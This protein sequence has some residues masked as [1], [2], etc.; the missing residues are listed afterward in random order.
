[1]NLITRIF[2]KTTSVLILLS[3]VQMHSLIFAQQTT[4]PYHESFESGLGNWTQ[5]TDEDFDWIENTGGTPSAFTGPNEAADGAT[6]LYL[7]SSGDGTGYPHKV[8]KLTSGVFDLSKLSTP[9][10]SFA[11]HMYG[12]NIGKLDLQIS[13]DNGSNWTSIWLKNGDQTNNWLTETIDL[14]SYQSNQVMFRFIGTTGDSFRSD[15]AIDRIQIN[16]IGALTVT[17]ISPTIAYGGSTITLTGSGFSTTPGDHVVKINGVQVSVISAT[18]TE[19]RIVLPAS[20]SSDRISVEV[21]GL[22]TSSGV[23]LIIPLMVYPYT[24]SFENGMGMWIQESNDDFNWIRNSGSTPSGNTGPSNAI[25]GSTYLYVESSDP[26]YPT[27]TGIITSPYLDLTS[28]TNPKLEFIYHL[29]GATMG[30]LKVEVSTD[31]KNWTT[32]LERSGDKGNQWFVTSA[33]LSAYKTSATLLRFVGTTAGSYTSDMAIDRIK[34]MGDN[35]VSLSGFSPAKATENATVTIAGVNFDLTPT[36]NIVKFN[37]VTATVTTASANQLTVLVPSGASNGKITV[38]TGGNTATS[39][40]DFTVVYP[41]TISDFSPKAAKAGNLVTITGTNFAPIRTN[42]I[43][44]FNGEVA[45][46]NIASST[47]LQVYVP[48]LATTG[49][50][51][52]ELNGFSKSTA[53][54]FSIIPSPVITDFSPKTAKE[55]GTV[56]IIGKNFD[57]NPSNNLVKFNGTAATVNSAT[58]T[59]LQVTVPTGISDGKI[60]VEVAGD[61]TTSSEDFKVILPPTITSFSP[62][63]G[64]IG[65]TIIITGTG[66]DATAVNNTVKLNGVPTTVSFS[67]N[68][69]LSITVPANATTGKIALEVNGFSVTTTTDFTVILSP[70]LPSISSFSPKS[71]KKGDVVTI[72]GANFS[73]T[74]A[75][76][77][78]KFNGVVA[79]LIDVTTTELKVTVPGGDVTGKITV[80]VN[81][82]VASSSEDFATILPPSITSFSPKSGNAGDTVTIT[83]TNFDETFTNNLVT[84]NGTLATIIAASSSQLQVIAPEGV[85]T[86]KISVTVGEETITTSEDFTV[87]TVAGLAKQLHKGKLTLYPNPMRDILHLKLVNN[88]TSE[89]KIGV[90]SLQGQ[91]VWQGTLRL[92]NGSATLNLAHLSVGEYVFII[93]VGKQVVSRRVLRK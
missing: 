58:S 78:V 25:D 40:R 59:E 57:L 32:L 7:E 31:G 37:G 22:Q 16:N 82:N 55:G 89:V 81:G 35:I 12:S 6:Y 53:T 36:N 76:N 74:A 69:E 1:M 86:G 13:I 45:I 21:N 75:N 2:S 51:T 17:S 42:N 56:T 3:M 48:N 43:V 50:I 62:S 24:E 90:Y 85:S 68:T 66:F 8:A 30:S 79:T 47:E 73:A 34:I 23:E 80:E 77:I 84:F 18:S 61:I 5:G 39:H 41:P 54:D 63:S 19:L 60:T 92:K 10:L 64:K 49:K 11:Y 28:L 71:G 72:S 44:K 87:K 26:N 20:V 93:E 4:Y 65:S 33:D 52:L 9:K 27:K 83:G 91:E 88:A 67:T 38:E 70:S 15:I 14:A 29:Y 46:V